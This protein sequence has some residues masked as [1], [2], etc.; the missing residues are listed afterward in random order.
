MFGAVGTE[1]DGSVAARDVTDVDS[2]SAATREPGRENGGGRSERQQEDV[3]RNSDKSLLECIDLG[4]RV[5]R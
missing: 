1:E 4:V 2:S 5:E 3:G